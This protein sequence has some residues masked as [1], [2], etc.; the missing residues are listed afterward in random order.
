MA[1]P[2]RIAVVSE[3]L[4]SARYGQ[5]GLTLL[6]ALEKLDGTKVVASRRSDAAGIRRDLQPALEKAP[7]A[8]VLLVGGPVTMPFFEVTLTPRLDEDPE[9]PT[10][11]PYGVPGDSLALADIALPTRAVGRIPDHP[12]DTAGAFARR[13][14]ALCGAA[15]AAHAGP[16]YLLSAKVWERTTAAM[17][18][19]L[20]RA[21]AVDL[22]PPRAPADFRS[23]PFVRAAALRQLFNLHGSDRE[24]PWF[25]QEGSRYPPAFDPAAADALAAAGKVQGAL[26]V[27]QACYG[28]FLLMPGGP[29]RPSQACSLTFL[30]KGAAAFLGSTTIAYGGTTGPMICSDVLA[31]E[32]LR[33]ASEGVA[34]GEALRKARSALASSIRSPPAGSELKTLLQFVLYG[35]PVRTWAAPPQAL[36]ATPKAFVAPADDDARTRLGDYARWSEEERPM[37]KSLVDGGDGAAEG[38]GWTEVASFTAPPDPAVKGLRDEAT[39]GGGSG[40]TRRVY[41]QVQQ[42]PA[43]EVVYFRERVERDGDVL[44]AQSTGGRSAVTIAEQ[45]KGNVAWWRQEAV[46]PARAAPRK[47]KAPRGGATPTVAAGSAGSGPPRGSAGGRAAAKKP[48]RAAPAATKRKAAERKKA[49]ARRS[50]AGRGP[51]GLPGKGRRGP[52]KKA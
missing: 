39:A 42:L 26:V 9:V 32:F 14:G 33:A 19:K 49:P 11:N 47:K 10:D 13:I 21:A 38:G 22:A 50:G 15:P 17:G 52:S 27:A 28:A 3:P 30:E 18:A 23:A 29:R 41:Q 35:D 36:R 5:S 7:G 16:Y 43:A 44:E 48:A 46:A 25:G 1:T 12:D 20:D 8:A 24:A 40:A 37:A 31:V 2:V 4:L 34:L 51:R 45:R 6:A